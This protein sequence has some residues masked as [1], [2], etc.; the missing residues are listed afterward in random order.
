MYIHTAVFEEFIKNGFAIIS[1]TETLHRYETPQGYILHFY[2]E[3]H[4]ITVHQ[5]TGR[6]KNLNMPI[7]D[8][9]RAWKWNVTVSSELS[10]ILKEIVALPIPGV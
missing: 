10:V 7:I 5:I 4:K 3:G 1:I 2:P 6:S 9:E 8:M